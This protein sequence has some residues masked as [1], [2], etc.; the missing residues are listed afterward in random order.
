MNSEV[1]QAGGDSSLYSSLM[2]FFFLHES[3]KNL[4][5]RTIHFFLQNL[6]RIFHVMNYLEP[7]LEYWFS[8]QYSKEAILIDVHSHSREILNS[9]T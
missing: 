7:G 2:E 5:T 9:L 3:H 6:F 4:E 1:F 8:H